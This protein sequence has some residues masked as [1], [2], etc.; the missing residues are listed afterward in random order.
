MTNEEWTEFWLNRLTEV[1]KSRSLSEN[2]LKNYSLA[3]RTFLVFKPGSPQWW[4]PKDLMRFLA[5]LKERGLAGSTLNLYQNGL[6]FFCRN[7]CRNPHFAEPL[8]KARQTQKLPAILSR[9]KI[10]ALL[11]AHPTP[12][13]RLALALAYGCGLRVSELALLQLGDLDFARSTLTVRLGKGGKDRTLMLPKSLEISLREYVK[14]YRPHTYLFEGSVPGQP[15]ARRTFQVFFRNALEKAGITHS[16]GIHSLR[17]AFATHLLESGTD[18]KVIQGLLGHANYKTT[19]RYARVA[20]HR[21]KLIESPVD[22]VWQ[23]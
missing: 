21:L 20:S 23:G 11:A 6:V 9:E 3:L 15:L 10:Q 1:A 13:H 18:L 12:K 4:R 2:T 22:R 7:V 19:E 16:G 5:G 14:N 8:P 17:H